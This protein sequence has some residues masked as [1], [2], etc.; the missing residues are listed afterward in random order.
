[1][2]ID[3][4]VVCMEVIETP[5]GIPL[6][7][8]VWAVRGEERHYFNNIM[9]LA[10]FLVAQDLKPARIPAEEGWDN[11]VDLPDPLFLDMLVG[12]KAEVVESGGK[13]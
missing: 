11:C 5:R 9:E 3:S 8:G 13:K 7:L 2:K 4:A 10:H 12:M 1:M 6:A